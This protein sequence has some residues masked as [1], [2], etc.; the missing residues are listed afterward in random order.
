MLNLTVFS[1]ISALAVTIISMYLYFKLSYTAKE[2]EKRRIGAQQK[3]QERLSKIKNFGWNEDLQSEKQSWGLS[4]K[5]YLLIS[6]LSLVIALLI[7]I[8]LKNVYIALGGGVIAYVLPRYVISHNRKKDYKLKVKLIK[9]A[10]QAIASAHTYKP[11]I[12]TA[13]QQAVSSMQYPIKRDF[14]LFLMDVE[15]GVTLHE[16]LAS[17]RKRV[18]IKYLDFFIKV[19]IIAEEEG[20]K[21]HELIKTCAE[22]IDQDMLVM[23]EFETEISAEKKTTIQ[24]LFLQFVMLGFMSFSQPQAF[25]AYTQTTFGKIFLFYIFIATFVVYQLAEKYT[26]MSPESGANNV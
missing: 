6:G 20:G 21:T 17:L 19:V 26:D 23:E 11:N 14:E 24:L 16:A 12:I 15:M 5:E 22:I 1:I 8:A 10:L 2:V 7:G 4:F 13:I 25:A 9:P 3:S 18:N